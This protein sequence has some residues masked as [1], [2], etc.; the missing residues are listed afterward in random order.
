MKTTTLSPYK[1]TWIEF[2]A[3]K[4]I[5]TKHDQKVI[6]KIPFNGKSRKCL[7]K[8]FPDK[9]SAE[10]FLLQFDASKLNKS[11]ECRIFSDKQ[12]G[13]RSR[14]NG[15]SVPFTTLQNQKMILINA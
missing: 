10:N 3:V 13:M 11:Y 9:K 6:D 4:G 15:Y 8:H 12:F 14:E 5:V 7:Y 1:I 2:R